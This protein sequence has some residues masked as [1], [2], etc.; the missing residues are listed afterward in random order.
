MNDSAGRDR[1]RS[2]SARAKKDVD[3]SDLNFKIGSFDKAD[4]LVLWPFAPGGDT[5]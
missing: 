4:T 5:H 3:T 2:H 1:D